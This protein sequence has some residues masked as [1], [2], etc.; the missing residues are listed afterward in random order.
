MRTSRLTLLFALAA[1]CIL[2]A[3]LSQEGGDAP[4]P[5][6]AP[7]PEQPAAPAEE[8][9]P[10]PA[11]A[12]EEKE[13][14]IADV[15]TDTV[16]DIA[17]TVLK[18]ND[19]VGDLKAKYQTSVQ[20]FVTGSIVGYAA[21]AVVKYFSLSVLKAVG[22]AAVGILAAVAGGFIGKDSSP[23]VG[24]M[25]EQYNKFD[26]K[27]A[28]KEVYKRLDLTKDGKVDLKDVKEVLLRT[29]RMLIKNNISLSIGSIA[30]ALVGLWR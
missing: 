12:P 20:K 3:A 21:G 9:A 22:V 19:P 29:E 27:A 15:L 5:A 28:E 26:S 4:A 24:Q 16:N 8:R 6:P 13:E 11:P 2:P 23:I 25:Y 10:A 1:L 30:G 18:S 14:H 17:G 7:A